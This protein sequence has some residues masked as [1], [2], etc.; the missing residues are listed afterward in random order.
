MQSVTATIKS[1]FESIL[2]FRYHVALLPISG[3]IWR[4]LMML[5]FSMT[6]I[7]DV[8][9]FRETLMRIGMKDNLRI[10]TWMWLRRKWG[11]VSFK[12][13]STF[14]LMINGLKPSSFLWSC[15]PLSFLTMYRIDGILSHIVSQ[16][17]YPHV[18]YIARRPP[19]VL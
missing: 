12:N 16:V 4:S 17:G 19:I 5:F 11:K 8:A 14:I 10:P 15:Q 13:L 7:K 18:L 1:L 2:G 9:G 3:M 6:R